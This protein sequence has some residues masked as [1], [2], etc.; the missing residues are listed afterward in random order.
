MRKKWGGDKNGKS[1]EDIFQ[2]NIAF[3][4]KNQNLYK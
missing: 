2:S 4:R 1:K 3:I